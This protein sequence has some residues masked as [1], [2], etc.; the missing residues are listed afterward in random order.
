MY[1][2]RF[3]SFRM[4]LEAMVPTSYGVPK[5]LDID[6]GEDVKEALH[7]AEILGVQIF[8]IEDDMLA[9]YAVR[10]PIAAPDTP[11]AIIGDSM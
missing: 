4:P 6:M 9:I 11:E 3:V 1:E 10:F 8:A 7:G 2:Y 5:S